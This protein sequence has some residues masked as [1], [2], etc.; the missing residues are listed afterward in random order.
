MR[1]LHLSSSSSSIDFW[2]SEWRFLR[3]ELRHNHWPTGI[4]GLTLCVRY[5]LASGELPKPKRSFSNFGAFFFFGFFFG[6][7]EAQQAIRFAIVHCSLG[8]AMQ[9]QWTSNGQAMD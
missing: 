5:S 1:L 8:P 3:P 4:I 6:S 9:K 7:S 2:P